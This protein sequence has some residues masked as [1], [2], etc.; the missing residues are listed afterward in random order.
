M[1]RFAARLLHGLHGGTIGRPRFKSAALA[2]AAVLLPAVHADAQFT[3]P[4]VADARP[5]EV[6]ALLREPPAPPA[7]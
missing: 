3:G 1:T 2:V 7:T 6:L 5:G 4:K